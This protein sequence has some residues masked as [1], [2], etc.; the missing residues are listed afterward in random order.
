M[1]SR[2][3]RKR[4]LETFFGHFPILNR[5]AGSGRAGSGRAGR[6]FSADPTTEPLRG[7]KGN[8]KAEKNSKNKK[9]ESKSSEN[10]KRTRVLNALSSLSG[11]ILGC[12]ALAERAQGSHGNAATQQ[13]IRN[14]IFKDLRFQ[15]FVSQVSVSSSFNNHF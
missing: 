4:F 11:P 7:K 12:A 5:V 6:K 10:N 2:A 3:G 1:S 8:P 13:N 9:N 14:Y 15:F